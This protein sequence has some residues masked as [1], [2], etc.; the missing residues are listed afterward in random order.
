ME[1][2]SRKTGMEGERRVWSEERG[3]RERHVLRARAESEGICIPTRVVE[4]EAICCRK[5]LGRASDDPVISSPRPDQRR[6]YII[7]GRKSF[8]PHPLHPM[9]NPHNERQAILLQ[10][11]VKSVVRAPVS[12]Q[13]HIQMKNKYS[14]IT[15]PQTKCNDIFQE[16]NQCLEVR[17]CLSPFRS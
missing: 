11:I 7:P 8:D 10:R 4:K 13:F 6:A 12:E 17:R 14:D 1:M 16:L 9:E 15:I 5:G 3:G 2:N